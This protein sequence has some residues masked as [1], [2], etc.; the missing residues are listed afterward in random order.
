MPIIKENSKTIV[1]GI[2]ILVKI[3]CTSNEFQFSVEKMTPTNTNIPAFATHPGEILL[4]EIEANDF[5]QIDF[6]KM[7][8]VVALE[9]CQLPR[10]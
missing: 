1:R 8:G 2:F 4:D 9:L 7:I 6:A 5:S 3:K 10:T